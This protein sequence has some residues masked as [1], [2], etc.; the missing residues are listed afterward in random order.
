MGNIKWD[1]P[2]LDKHRDRDSHPWCCAPDG[3]LI[4]TS[5]HLHGEGESK[6]METLLAEIGCFGLMA[7]QQRWEALV[8]D[9]EQ[10]RGG[11]H[12]RAHSSST[13]RQDRP[14]RRNDV[15]S[16]LPAKC[17]NTPDCI[18]GIIPYRHGRGTISQT[19]DRKRKHQPRKQCN[20]RQERDPDIRWYMVSH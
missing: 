18:T 15:V 9:A 7:P 1:W 3:P 12:H 16:Q 5:R 2:W 6:S 20:W 13:A 19:S 14:P 8:T 10:R 4:I 11:R 17:N